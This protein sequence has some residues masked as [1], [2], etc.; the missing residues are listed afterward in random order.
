MKNINK[1]YPKGCNL[2][3]SKEHRQKP[4][5]SQRASIDAVIELKQQHKTANIVDWRKN[6]RAKL[7]LERQS[8]VDPPDLPH[9]II[10][11]DSLEVLNSSTVERVMAI[12]L[13][14][15]GQ[16]TSTKVV[17]KAPDTKSVLFD[18]GVAEMT[19]DMEYSQLIQPIH[20]EPPGLHQPQR[21]AGPTNKKKKKEISHQE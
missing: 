12:K 15:T 10:T 11:P 2:K 21:K 16:Y 9:P 18:R 8:K 6:C 17:G 4:R 5:S 13:Q 3:E 20:W 1:A 14:S 19:M 7:M